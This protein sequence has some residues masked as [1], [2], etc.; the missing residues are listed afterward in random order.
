[1]FGF[2]WK[3]EKK[4]ANSQD[5]AVIGMACRFPG[6]ENYQH[7][8]KNLIRGVNSVKEV[9]SER[10]NWRELEGDP[11]NQRNKTNI[12]WGGFIHDIDK[13]DPLF[14]NISPKEATYI[15][16][17]H[18]IFLEAVWHAIGDAGYS[19]ESLSGKKV[20]V[21]VGVSKNDYAELMRANDEEITSFIST[22]TVH[23][24]LAN[25]VSFLLNIHGPSEA[26]DTACSSSLV[27]L[28]SAIKD[29]NNGE[30]E[31]AIVGGVNALLAPTMFISHSKSGMLA[32]DGKCKTFDHKANGYVRSEG[33]GVLLLK[34]LEKAREDADHIHGVLIGSSINHGGRSNF[35]T[36]PNANAQARVVE[37]AIKKADIHPE[38]ITY[39]ETHGTGTPLGDPIEINGLKKAFSNLNAPSN[40]YCGLGSVKTNIGHLESAAG[41]AGII[42]IL[43]AMQHKQLP[44]ILHFERI[45]PHIELS[46]SQFYIVKDK[47]LW[48]QLNLN[49]KIIPRRAGV[50]AFGMGGVNAHVL[51]EEAP[52][53]KERKNKPNDKISN[54]H[55]IILSAKENRLQHSV[56]A[57]LIY[58]NDS[59]RIIPI[60]DDALSS[61]AYTLQIGRN[62]F[63]E[64][65]CFV[66]RSIS[67]L[68]RKLECFIHKNDP[69]EYFY[70]I[71][72]QSEIKKE[73]DVESKQSDLVALAKAWISGTS[74]DWSRLY[75]KTRPQRLPLPG[76]PFVRKSCWPDS[77]RNLQAP[78]AIIESSPGQIPIESKEKIS[79]IIRR[80]EFS[81]QE[82][83]VQAQPM[84]PG[85]GHLE[86]VLSAVSLS[87]NGSLHAKRIQ[88]KDLF[89]LVPLR[90][91]TDEINL[92]IELTSF[93]HA[94][95]FA[96]KCDGVVHSQGSLH[97]FDQEL[98]EQ[99]QIDFSQILSR[100]SQQITKD[101][102]YESF[103]AYGLAY[104]P[105]LKVIEQFHYN[106]NEAFAELRIEGKLENQPGM[107]TALIDG[108]FQSVVGFTLYSM[109][110]QT[111]QLV[112]YYAE[113]IDLLSPMPPRCYVHVTL[114]ENE[115]SDGMTCFT[116]HVYDMQGKLV[117]L[118]GPFAKRTL[119]I[120][121]VAS[122]GRDALVTPSHLYYQTVWKAQPMLI[123]HN[124]PQL[125]WVIV[126]EHD[127]KFSKSLC[128]LVPETKIL[129]IRVGK[130]FKILSETV[131]SQVVC[132]NP[133]EAMD[134]EKLLSFLQERGIQPTHI[135]HT[136]NLTSSKMALNKVEAVDQFL[137][138]GIYTLLHLSRTL[139]LDKSLSQIELLYVYRQDHHNPL[140]SLIS[141]FSRTLKYENP[142][143]NYLSIG[144]DDPSDLKMIFN[145]LM[146]KKDLI[147]SEVRYENQTRLVR[148]IKHLEETV[149]SEKLFSLIRKNGVY[150]ITG[151]AGG[152]GAFFA[153]YLSRNYQ[154]TILLIGRT[155]MNSSI[156]SLISEIKKEGGEAEYFVA[157]VSDDKKLKVV[158]QSINK[159]YKQIHGIIHA[160]GGID[161]AFI[162]AKS[163]TH[164][165]R[166][167][168]QK[169]LAAS[170]S[171]SCHKP[172][173]LIFSSYFPPLRRLFQIR[174]SV[175]MQLP[176][177][178]WMSFLPIE[179]ILCL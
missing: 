57:L 167:L 76:Y 36:A 125:G 49:N 134:Y 46:N 130:K 176:I 63:E 98:S 159:K 70:N 20:G 96:V 72:K 164:L 179:I 173:L 113:T 9:P 152:L 162:Y 65:V 148:E 117:A 54:D 151:G 128:L 64:R 78:S 29:I 71:L 141:G 100:C 73:I 170:M 104:G 6:A 106:E 5:V 95:H 15:D 51:L 161:D 19:T 169:Y 67:D 30:C 12:K 24:I 23:S 34:P 101:R 7:Y 85:A 94:K 3:K 61:L 82:H 143:L 86:L 121:G 147:L 149:K 13:F 146:S 32:L 37:S 156:L 137:E 163:R 62:E 103:K 44:G 105:S 129:S 2:T 93:N 120:E 160:A 35:L 81:M 142:R 59:D 58:L 140:N 112:P 108:I 33:V 153:K 43:L 21:Y 135:V 69:A 172:G 79:L 74:I 97:E 4:R 168:P 132:I 92:S 41:M 87:K 91:K 48:P 116:M 138:Y 109:S 115:S 177:A 55:L 50:S 136:W 131:D 80:D 118:I 102:L 22:G 127:G 14:F 28:H 88:F 27:A 145:E 75:L 11:Q 171:T 99:K 139:I 52:A 166:S 25:R 1:M 40:Q 84:M 77:L 17:Q 38:T 144:L 56:E 123:G 111:K 110:R 60:D 39:I 150:V 154:A 133:K 8:W 31:L 68:K 10:W 47:Q 119:Q 122:P 158:F 157:D 124:P 66:V 89:W 107:Y 165:Q 42:K 90:P 83:I 126:F 16:P 45:N 175:I 18:R 178:F 155:P 114:L 26:I 53:V 174:G